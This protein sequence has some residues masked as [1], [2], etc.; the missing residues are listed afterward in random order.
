L[1][2]EDGVLHHSIVSKF[3]ILVPDGQA[4][5][6]GGMAIDVTDRLRAEE[7]LKEADRR[8]DEFLA[9]LA[10]ELRNPL[11]PI[12]NALYIMKQASADPAVLCQVRE[13]MERQV[14]HMTRMVD[15]LLDVSRITRGKIELRK[16]I[17]DL[18]SVM[19]RTVEAIR[20]LLEDRQQTLTVDLPPEP[21][22]LAADPTRLEQVLANLLNNA[23][24]YTDQGGHI[25]LSARREA[26]ELVLR[27]R[28]TGEGIA[29]D[30][31]TCI[32]EP[33]V[34]ADRVLHQ[35]QG[36]LGIGLTLVRRLV[37][38]HGGTVAAHSDG[39]GKGSEFVVRLPALLPKQ[40]IGAEGSAGERGESVGAA[41][42]RRILVVDD[43]VDAAE[44]LAILLRLLGHDVRV[45]HDGPAGLAAVEAAPPDLVF[46]D[47]GM[48][49]MN[50]YEVAQRL[51][52]RPGP[53]HVVL[54]AVTGW[55]QEEDR[56]RSRE[57]GFDHHLVKPVEPEALRQ[58]LALLR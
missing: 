6:V 39:P 47:I 36:G 21:V 29:P 38:M 52:Q 42:Q 27:V 3:P 30:M 8:K 14:H 37:E 46:L 25:G 58:V 22:R 55:G 10:H 16:E 33:F 20:P 2:H 45:A 1:E 31:L 50:G 15:D 53:D 35:S 54:V 12:R 40:P 9:M 51:R 18:A 43:N 24:K 11:A 44:S 26:S 19:E 7:A 34:Q 32:F 57:A 56:R 48:P 4:A 5:L 17:V 49:V 13:M 41:R 28:D 23:A